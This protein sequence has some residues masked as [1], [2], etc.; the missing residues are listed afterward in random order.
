MVECPD[1]GPKRSNPEALLAPSAPVADVP[2]IE[3]LVGVPGNPV[4]LIRSVMA[5]RWVASLMIWAVEKV[6]LSNPG[7][8]LASRI[9]W[10]REPGPQS[11]PVVATKAAGAD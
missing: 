5:G 4:M 2:S 8:V 11:A 6:M 9:A 3:T 10:R 1:S 7:R